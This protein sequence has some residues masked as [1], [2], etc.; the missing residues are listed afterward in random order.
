MRNVIQ[1]QI[2]LLCARARYNGQS[3]KFYTKLQIVTVCGKGDLAHAAAPQKGTFCLKEQALTPT[4][5]E[6]QLRARSAP[7]ERAAQGLRA[8]TAPAHFKLYSE[9]RAVAI[10]PP[11]FLSP[12]P[13]CGRIKLAAHHNSRPHP[14]AQASTAP[15]PARPRLS[16]TSKF[17][18]AQTFP[19]RITSQARLRPTGAHMLEI[20]RYVHVTKLAANDLPPAGPVPA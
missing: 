12:H 2:F 20:R 7:P 5:H 13:P 10:M 6:P 11:S 3:T 9:P 8:I 4:P 17:K 1:I 16:T 14:T 19:K 15:V 18:Y